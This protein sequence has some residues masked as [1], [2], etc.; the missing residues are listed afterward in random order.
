MNPDP[1]TNSCEKWT[2]IDEEIAHTISNDLEEYPEVSPNKILHG[3]NNFFKDPKTRAMIVTLGIVLLLSSCSGNRE[4]LYSRIDSILNDNNPAIAYSIS[5]KIQELPNIE[6]IS[7]NQAIVPKNITVPQAEEQKKV[8]EKDT[9]AEMTPVPDTHIIALDTAPYGFSK[10]PVY[11]I[12]SSNT[13]CVWD[14]PAR[15]PLNQ[16]DLPERREYISPEEYTRVITFFNV[17]DENNLRYKAYGSRH[18]PYSYC[19]SFVS[20]VTKALGV[21]IPRFTYDPQSGKIIEFSAA[22]QYNWLQKEGKFL[23]WFEIDAKTAQEYASAGFP[24]VVSHPDHIAMVIPGEGAYYKRAFYPQVSQA[25]WYNYESLD[26]PKAFERFFYPEEQ[27][28]PFNLEEEIAKA[29]ERREKIKFF[30]N[31]SHYRFLSLRELKEEYGLNIFQFK[32]YQEILPEKTDN[33]QPISPKA[34]SSLY[35]E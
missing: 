33:K 6:F 21:E 8:I 25:G 35:K 11:C 4:F 13:K 18:E 7:P 34:E 14:E 15:L 28:D 31:T 10:P 20:D 5:L 27:K 1:Q 16:E 29:P 32:Q 22:H 30:V 17:A 12:D 19:H 3:F 2:D 24:T 23:G 9:P 26:L